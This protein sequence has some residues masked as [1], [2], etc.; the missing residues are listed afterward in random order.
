[1]MTLKMMTI[2]MMTLK[3]GVF[4]IFKWNTTATTTVPWVQLSNKQNKNVLLKHSS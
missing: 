2:K 1:M 3:K 4:I